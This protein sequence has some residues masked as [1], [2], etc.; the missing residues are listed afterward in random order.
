MRSPCGR[1]WTGTV[2]RT[3]RPGERR[4]LDHL[5]T[6]A[7]ICRVTG[8]RAGSLREPARRDRQGGRVA[9][10]VLATLVA[11]ALFQSVAG[12]ATGVALLPAASEGMLAA[13]ERTAVSSV[14]DRSS[15]R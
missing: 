7:G 13:L 6:F 4:A 14:S 8:P 11:V 5:R 10:R 1:R 9:R 2:R 12:L 15:C 3:A